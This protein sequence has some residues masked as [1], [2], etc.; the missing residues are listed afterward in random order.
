MKEQEYY[1]SKCHEK[2]K[3][4]NINFLRKLKQYFC[5]KCVMWAW[6]KENE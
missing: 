2:I 5:D 1:C 4:G 6:K 3:K